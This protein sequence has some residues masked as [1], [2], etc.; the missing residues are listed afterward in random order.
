MIIEFVSGS[1]SDRDVLVV[2]VGTGGLAN[3]TDRLPE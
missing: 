2:P 1:A 3:V